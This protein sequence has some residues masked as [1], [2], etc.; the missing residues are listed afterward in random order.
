GYNHAIARLGQAGYGG[1]TTGQGNPFIS[2]LDVVIGVFIDNA[3]PVENHQFHF[4]G[5]RWEISATL[6]NRSRKLVS[7][8]KRLLRTAGS[9]AITIT[10]S[11]KLSTGFLSMASSF[12]ASP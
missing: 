1:D 9:S 7:S 6:R 10:S 8:R 2:R 3:I 11:K 5:T 12:M 4:A